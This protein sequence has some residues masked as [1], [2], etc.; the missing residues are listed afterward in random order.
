VTPGSTL[1]NDLQS[2]VTL[3]AADLRNEIEEIEQAQ[4]PSDRADEGFADANEDLAEH[5]GS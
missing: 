4:S 2:R 5:Q 3:L 1:V